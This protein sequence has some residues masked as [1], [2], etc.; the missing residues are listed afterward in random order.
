MSE[1]QGGGKLLGSPPGAALGP[2]LGDQ[3]GA[4]EEVTDFLQLDA[5]GQV[6]LQVV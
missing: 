4:A 3:P 5:S 2:G 6:R 1:V